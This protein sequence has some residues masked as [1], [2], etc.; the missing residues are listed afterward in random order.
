MYI[1][2]EYINE[3]RC[4]LS[5]FEC[6]ELDFDV[7]SANRNSCRNNDLHYNFPLFSSNEIDT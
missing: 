1:V 6:V 7:S 5:I 4:Q 3:I 2:Y